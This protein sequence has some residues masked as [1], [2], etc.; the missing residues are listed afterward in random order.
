MLRMPSRANSSKQPMCSPPTIVIGSPASIGMMKA[1]AKFAVKS[2]SPRASESA[3]GIRRHVADVGEALRPQELVGDILG[4]DANAG[5]FR[6]SD[7]DCFG[8]A[9]LGP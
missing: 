3:A 8:W 1:G 4:R 2:T 9:L 5:D 6:Q 7:G